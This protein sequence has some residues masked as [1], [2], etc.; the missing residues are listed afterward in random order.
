MTI[1]CITWWFFA[2]GAF[3]GAL[4]G[5]VLTMGLTVYLFREHHE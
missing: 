5:T 1:A 3:A 4:I 2:A